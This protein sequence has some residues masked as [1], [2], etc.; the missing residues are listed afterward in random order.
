[1]V[2]NPLFVNSFENGRGFMSQLIPY[3]IL[4]TILCKNFAK[5]INFLGSFGS[6]FSSKV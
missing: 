1:M 2:Q 3:K 6:Q 4:E 5:K